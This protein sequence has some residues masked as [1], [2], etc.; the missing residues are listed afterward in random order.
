MDAEGKDRR[1][2]GWPIN[3]HSPVP[4]TVGTA[5]HRGRLTVRRVA[6]CPSTRRISH[7]LPMTLTKPFIVVSISTRPNPFYLYGYVLVAEDGEWWQL[8]R[9]GVGSYPSPQDRP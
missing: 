4:G 8:E 1:R 7:V 3:N 9:A 5:Q 2:T 6:Q